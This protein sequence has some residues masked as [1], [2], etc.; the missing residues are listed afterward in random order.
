MEISKKIRL[1]YH[2]TIKALILVDSKQYSMSYIYIYI[3]IIYIYIY[4]YVTFHS[5][6]T[7]IYI[8]IYIYMT[9]H[10]LWPRNCMQQIGKANNPFERKKL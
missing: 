7:Y 3:Y 4:V 2:N 9:F 1:V 8:Y 5:L 6:Y 10:S